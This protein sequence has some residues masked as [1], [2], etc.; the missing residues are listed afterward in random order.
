MAPVS[1]PVLSLFCTPGMVLVLEH[2][3]SHCKELAS[4]SP[5]ARPHTCHKHCSCRSPGLGPTPCCYLS[6]PTGTHSPACSL[7][8]TLFLCSTL[9]HLYTSG[10]RPLHTLC[11]TLTCR[12]SCTPVSAWAH[13]ASGTVYCTA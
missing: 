6:P 7:C 2:L 12:Q 3:Y 9:S 5:S 8:C 11:C 13:T 1:R 4:L 10:C